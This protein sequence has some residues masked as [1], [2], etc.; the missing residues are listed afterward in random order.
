MKTPALS[1]P[2]GSKSYLRGKARGVVRLKY[3]LLPAILLL[4]GCA[5]SQPVIQVERV[6]IPTFIPVA[7]TLTQ[8]TI[9]SFPP[10][11]T[12]GKAI[13][14]LNQAVQACNADKAA[15]ATLVAPGSKPPKN[16]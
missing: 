6:N 7:S 3:S 11:V 2:G 12:W 5:S 16:P 10:N 9:V 14:T 4:F 13:G 1:Q 8:P 15:I